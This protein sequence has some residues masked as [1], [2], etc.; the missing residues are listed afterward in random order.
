MLAEDGERLHH[1]PEKLS[2][3]VGVKCPPE[4]SAT[5]R[6]GPQSLVSNLLGVLFA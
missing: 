2:R 6:K 4:N 5:R 1:V 3:R